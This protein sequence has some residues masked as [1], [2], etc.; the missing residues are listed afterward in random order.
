MLSSLVARDAENAAYR[1]LAGARVLLTG[2]PRG[3]GLGLVR[4]FARV[5][6]RLTVQS[7]AGGLQADALAADLAG[8]GVD[9]RLETGPFESAVAAARFAQS[10][11]RRMGGI[12]AVVNVISMSTDE[13]ALAVASEDV[14]DAIHDILLPACLI[15]RVAANRM[16]LMLK[17]GSI[18]NILDPPP[19]VSRA[20]SAFA[21]FA[22]AALAAMT[23]IEAREW[24]R[25]GVRINGL[26]LAPDEIHGADLSLASRHGQTAALALHLASRKGRRI[27]GL[28]LDPAHVA[29]GRA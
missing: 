23:R 17:G 13:C 29:E 12:D 25:N 18:L 28:V 21:G 9:L 14:E 10:A 27:S 19:S 22:R 20:D 4:A 7:L 6:A 3:P 8:M 24:S 15:T 11:A 1:E 5:R 2:V 16:R 26:C